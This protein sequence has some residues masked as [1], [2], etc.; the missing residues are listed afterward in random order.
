MLG[1]VFVLWL[2]ALAGSNLAKE[3]E[4]EENSENFPS[5]HRP[6]N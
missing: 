4:P 2:V 5:T 3:N 1:N 6:S